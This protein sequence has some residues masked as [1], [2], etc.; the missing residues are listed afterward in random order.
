MYT[1]TVQEWTEKPLPQPRRGCMFWWKI[2]I[3]HFMFCALCHYF[4]IEGRNTKERGNYLST[5]G[6]DCMILGAF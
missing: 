3:C 4:A 6:D 2:A 5:A 1:R